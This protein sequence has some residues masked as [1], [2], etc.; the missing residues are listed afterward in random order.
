MTTDGKYWF[1]VYTKSRHEKCVESKLIQKDF[2]TFLPLVTEKKRWTDRIQKVDVPL[3]KSYLFVKTEPKN[4]LYVLQTH[5]VVKIIKI[6]HDYTRVPEYQ[7]E[8]LQA[9][10]A[11]RLAITPE[12]YFKTGEKV[13]VLYGPLKDKIGTVKSVKGSNKLFL[14]IDAINYAFSTPIEMENVKKIKEESERK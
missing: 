6:G 8:A 1:A 5:G 12:D 14:K 9:V 2:I 11:E 13:K 10:L 3:I 7:I 4:L